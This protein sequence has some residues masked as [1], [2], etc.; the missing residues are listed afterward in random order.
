MKH[1][2]GYT[3]S[4]RFRCLEDLQ[5][6]S[7]DLCLIYC[8]WEYCN[9][10]HKY[11]PNLRTSYVLHIVRSGKG[12]LEINKHK[13]ELKEGDAFFIAP[14][15]EAWYEAAICGLDLPATVQKKMQNMRDFRG[16]ILSGM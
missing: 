10:G 15:V 4:A 7:A 5:K 14:E 12:I 8:G 9:P 16:E 6:D 3:N 2:A 13:Y 1:V 11:G